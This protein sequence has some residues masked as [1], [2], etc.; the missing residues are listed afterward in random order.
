M[1]RQAV[2]FL[3]LVR[4]TRLEASRQGQLGYCVGKVAIRKDISMA[5]KF[6]AKLTKEEQDLLKT[7]RQIEDGAQLIKGALGVGVFKDLITGK[8]EEKLHA[9]TDTDWDLFVNALKAANK[10]HMCKSEEAINF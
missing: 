5:V 1:K 10:I 7:L 4:L 6:Q 8:P 9:I 2:R 3:R